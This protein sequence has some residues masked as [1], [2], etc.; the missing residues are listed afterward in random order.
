M[1]VSVSNERGAALVLV[2]VIA[3]AVAALAMASIV[4]SSTGSLTSKFH[5][6]ETALQGAGDGGLE[7]GRDSVNRMGTSLP[8][9][10]YITLEAGATIYDAT[11]TPLPGVTRFVYAGRTGGRSGGSASSGQY[12]SNYGSLLS[13]IRDTRG[14]VAARR[15]LVAEE[16]WARFAYAMNRWS[17][18]GIAFGCGESAA[19]PVHSNG[20]IYISC[21]GT[22]KVLFM[23]AV[24]AVGSVSGASG[25]TFLQG[26]S[27][28]VQPIKWPTPTDLAK[29]RSYAQEAGASYDLVGGATVTTSPTVRIEFLTID[30]NGNGTIEPTEGY[31]RVFRATNS[32]D[33]LLAYVT[34]KRWPRTFGGG[35]ATAADPN[36][37]SPNC[38]ANAQLNGAGPFAFRTASQVYAGTAGSAATKT[39]AVRTL[40]TSAS[41]RCFLG[42]DPRLF[43]ATTGDTLTPSPAETMPFGQWE[44]RPGGL[45]VP[46]Q[47]AVVRPGDQQYLF[48]MQAYANFKGVIYVSGSVAV[49]GRLR[50][51]LTVVTTGTV[52]LADDILYT[53]P[54]GTECSENG[55][56]L[57]ISTPEAILIH[58]NNVNSPFRVNNIS[59]GQFD[60]TPDNEIFHAFLFTLKQYYG[61]NLTY[62]PGAAAGEACAT[63]SAARSG[64]VRISGGIIQDDV[65][66]AT[67][68]WNRSGWAEL[69]TYDKCGVTA[70]PPYFPTTG[71]FLRNR[72]YELDPVWLNKIGVDGY[73]QTLQAK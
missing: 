25:A 1:R 38:G 36:L 10:G 47:L 51:R 14:A 61:D 26:Y 21:G 58:D 66:A 32:A 42:G 63:T 20:S 57:G 7:L 43:Q 23:G 34:G 45:P 27:N 17:N 62:N 6:K 8:D 24:S 64:C 67:F 29:L 52:A 50:G 13:V 22:P 9:S 28:G 40:L 19:G 73:F 11:G 12:G 48:P 59:R 15:M 72:Y 2:L 70:P 68:S 53:V 65:G 16:S 41:R 3:I 35:V 31:F 5:Y 54:P 69:H 18:S 37:I 56:A 71:R 55:D 60:D 44:L 33:T 30:V 46:A 4:L 39:T 49:S